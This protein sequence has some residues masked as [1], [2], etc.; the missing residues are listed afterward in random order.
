MALPAIV[1]HGD[2]LLS[3]R[4]MDQAAQLAAWTAGTMRICQ[5][6]S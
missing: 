4:I 2:A 6:I 1:S 3:R 5:S